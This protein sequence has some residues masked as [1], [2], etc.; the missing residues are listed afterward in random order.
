MRRCAPRSNIALSPLLVAVLSDQLDSEQRCAVAAALL[1][2]GADV[3]YE[4]S[5]EGV[6]PVACRAPSRRQA[7]ISPRTLTVSLF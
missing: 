2:A 3:D 6:T 7:P 4:D 5:I 1:A